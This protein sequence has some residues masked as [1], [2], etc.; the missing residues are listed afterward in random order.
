MLLYNVTISIDN[1]VASEWLKWMKETHIPEVMATTYF[2]K[3]QICKMLSE[4]ADTGGVTYAIQYFCRNMDDF[5]EYQRDYA[6]TLQAKQLQRYPNQFV[7][8]R[9][10]LELVD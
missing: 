3:F 2:V 1:A 7:A 9:T 8:F 6:P 4:E 5:E 10:L